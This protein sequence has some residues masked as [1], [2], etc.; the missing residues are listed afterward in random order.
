MSNRKQ[1]G[2][3]GKG[4]GGGKKVVPS[5]RGPAGNPNVFGDAYLVGDGELP[6]LKI[7]PSAIRPPTNTY[8]ASW[9]KVSREGD[10][11]LL[12]FGQ[13]LERKLVSRVDIRMAMY[14]AKEL[15]SVV[16]NF[17]AAIRAASSSCSEEDWEVDSE[18]LSD[19]SRYLLDAATAAAFSYSGTE[20]EIMFHWV[21]SLDIHHAL[22]RNTDYQYRG[23]MPVVSIILSRGQL[24]WVIE[25]V[26]NLVGDDGEG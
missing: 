12:S 3:P 13:R 6:S 26:L 24:C 21:S 15:M 11:L 17:V 7:V 2:R 1:R 16:S 22:K 14:H 18:E 4:R 25:K 5:Q 8:S 9:F 23:P 20:A 10:S 19:P